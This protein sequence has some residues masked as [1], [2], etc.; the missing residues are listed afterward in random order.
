MICSKPGVRRNRKAPNLR[1]T[2]KPCNESWI[3]LSG[4]V[5]AGLLTLFA[6]TKTGVPQLTY[7]LPGI[8]QAGGKKFGRKSRLRAQR[9]TLMATAFI[10]LPAPGY[11]KQ[12]GT[13]TGTGRCVPWTRLEHFSR[14]EPTAKKPS[15][16]VLQMAEILNFTGSTRRNCSYESLFPPCFLRAYFH[17]SRC[18]SKTYARSLPGFYLFFILWESLFLDGTDG[19]TEQK[20]LRWLP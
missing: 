13:S 11:V 17:L 8:G 4:M 9:Q 1:S 7:R 3:S 15:A 2:S 16:G 6:Q 12:S 19:T 5:I 14:R 10:S 18:G 20:H